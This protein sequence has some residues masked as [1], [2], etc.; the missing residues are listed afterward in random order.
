MPEITL[1][2]AEERD[3]KK[4]PRSEGYNRRIYLGVID[5]A[6]TSFDPGKALPL[7][8]ETE[9]SRL[10]AIGR[11]GRR[12]EF[13]AGRLLA[14]SL[15]S[16]L[17]GIPADRVAIAIDPR[18]KPRIEGGPS[19]GI[20]HSGGLVLCVVSDG[21]L[22]VDIERLGRRRCVENLAACAFSSAERDALSGE[23]TE[24]RF[25][26]LWTLKEAH[27]KRLGGGLS[28]IAKAPSFELGSGGALSASETQADCDYICLGM[29]EGPSFI[30]SVAYDFIPSLPEIVFDPRFDPPP[31]LSPTILYAP[32]R[33]SR[34]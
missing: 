28:D 11:E 3:G 34:R 16:A 23:G 33:A 6:S 14:K 13:L 22:G 19:L 8:D 32:S 21:G 15:V 29:G 24:K 17:L 25:Y 20:A 18:G 4:D 2:R 1:A 30:A 12:R 31:G 27:V 10:S 7:L 9:V 26:A 5:C